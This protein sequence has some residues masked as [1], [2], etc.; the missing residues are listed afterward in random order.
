LLILRKIRKIG[1]RASDDKIFMLKLP[2]SQA[3]WLR[4]ARGRGGEGS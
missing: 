2:N 3:L 4:E 1:A